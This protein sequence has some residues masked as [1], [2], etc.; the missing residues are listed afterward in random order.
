LQGIS[1]EPQ[2]IRCDVLLAE[3][4]DLGLFATFDD[5]GEA[6]VEQVERID[7]NGPLALIC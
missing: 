6:V 3:T 1:H 5:D 2:T 4:V 7:S